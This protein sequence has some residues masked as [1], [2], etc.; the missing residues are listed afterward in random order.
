MGDK[1]AEECAS[2]ILGI[3]YYERGDFKSAITLLQR[4]LKIAKEIRN[5]DGEGKACGNLGNVY[6]RLGD[7]EKA[8]DYHESDLK[9]AK[10]LGDKA[11]KT[12]LG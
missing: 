7:V 5:K 12:C 1:K 3:S 10:E 4:S 11:G 9:I 2:C 8:I 6:Y